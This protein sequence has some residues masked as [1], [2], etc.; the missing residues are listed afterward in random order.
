M[1]RPVAVSLLLM[2]FAS[3]A[4]ATGRELIIIDSNVP[5]IRPG[6]I[7]ET[8]QPL[9]LFKGERL[10]LVGAEGAVFRLEGPA[11]GPPAINEAS[12]VSDDGVLQALS[13]LFSSDVD[14][15]TKAAWGGFRGAEQ[16]RDAHHPGDVW[17]WNLLHSDGICV[18]AGIAPSL[19]RPDAT[20]EQDVVLLHLSTGKEADVGFAAGQHS[21]TWPRSV[22]LLD[23][24]EYAV[25]DARSLWERRLT[26]RIVPVGEISTIRQIAWMSDAGCLRQA[27]L[28]VARLQ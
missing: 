4:G 13:R 21:T 1:V 6:T 20:G 19:W 15:A 7:V 10:T 11:S 24:G 27:R 14:P 17:A 26:V 3:I 9:T 25:R 22:P 2:L 18:P 5:R 23:G 12:P 8:S 16:G 28:L